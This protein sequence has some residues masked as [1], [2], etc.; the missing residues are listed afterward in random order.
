MQ[1]M[2][3]GFSQ[4]IKD[5]EDADDFEADWLESLKNAFR[6]SAN[7]LLR[8]A[9]DLNFWK[10]VKNQAYFS[11]GLDEAEIEKIIGSVELGETW[12]NLANE[13]VTSLAQSIQAR[14]AELQAAAA[15]TGQQID[16]GLAAGVDQNAADPAAS[17]EAA[18]RG[19]IS[20]AESA[21]GVQSPS[22]VFYGIGLNV[23]AGL[24]E[25]IF[26]GADQAI[27]AAQWLAG[28]IE[29]TMRAALDIHSPSGVARMMGGFFAEGFAQG[30]ENGVSRV[31]KSMDR[32]SRAVTPRLDG[33]GNPVSRSVH[34]TV[35][36][37]GK[38]MA[39]ALAPLMDTALGDLNWDM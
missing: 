21:L 38:A 11:D 12:M 18:A 27:A 3:A 23:D 5:Y 19:V 26:A 8:E 24:A 39:Q 28:E 34:V 15:E 14:E 35:N 22:K 17:A 7:D 37:D 4:G 10:L 33:N 31:E 29:N 1:T 13:A 25:G 6:T 30:I 16:A 20:G 9:P 36:M 32:L 2:L